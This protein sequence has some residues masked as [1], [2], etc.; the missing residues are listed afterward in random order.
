MVTVE[1]DYSCVE[2]RLSSGGIRCPNCD[3]VLCGW[4]HGR[5]RQVEGL[6]GPVRPRR[7]RC[8]ACLVTHV[9]LPVTVLLRRSYAAQWIWSALTARAC[10]AGHRRIAA[11]LGIPAATVRGW[12]RRLGSRLEPVR[13][14]FVGVAIAAGVDVAI[15]DTC[16][17][18]WRNAL[19]AVATAAS[20]ITSRF[21]A[22]GFGGTVTL[23]QVAVAVS[24]GRLLAPGWPPQ[25]G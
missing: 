6:G 22:H 13:A 17:C 25:R 1:A 19:G 7:A 15:P 4:G 23:D 11:D 10:G 24:G 8:R 16:G 20:A 5:T 2:S 18:G 12:L 9:L 21:G 14:W 3:G